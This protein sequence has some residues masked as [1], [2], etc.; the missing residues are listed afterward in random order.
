VPI[1]FLPAKEDETV[2]VP[3]VKDAD[4][5]IEKQGARSAAMQEDS[6]DDAPEETTN[7]DVKEEMLRQMEMESEQQRI[8][9][10]K[11]AKRQE[12]KAAQQRSR[13]EQKL[14]GIR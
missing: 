6:D 12:S 5:G 7:R 3:S 1:I 9:D 4:H 10:E 11:K 8:Q 2:A 13:L 14:K